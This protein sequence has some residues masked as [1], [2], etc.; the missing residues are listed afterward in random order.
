MA[1]TNPKGGT[2]K[3]TS[4]A[5]LAAALALREKRVLL[6]DGDEQ[7]TATRILTNPASVKGTLLNVLIPEDDRL[8]PLDDVLIHTQVPGLDLI[9]GTRQISRFEGEGAAAVF[10][11][12][13][14]LKG[15]QRRYDFAI[16]DTPPNT[17]LLVVS[18]LAASSHALGIVQ[19]ESEGFE[20]FRAF[21]RS[22][23][24]AQAGNSRLEILG[25]LCTMY[26]SRTSGSAQVYEALRSQFPGRTFQTIIHRQ[27]R[28]SECPN[29]HKPIQYHAPRSS[30]AQ[31]YG[32]LAD[33]ILEI[34]SGG[35]K[36][37]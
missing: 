37:K 26:D 10:R 16:I 15:L 9:P 23:R 18:A 34:L 12:K 31:E 35:G 4:A 29:V 32:A 22:V 5:N 33:E 11:M 28:L 8:P 21:L 17:G 25:A 36:R 24:A 6:V 27:V 3:S 19:A 30:G 2:G 7:T 13:N 14:F 1:I 20:G